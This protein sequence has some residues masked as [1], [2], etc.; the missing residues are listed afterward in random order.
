M[1][2]DRTHECMDRDDLEQLQI[3]RL[4]ATLHRVHQNVAFY[5]QSLDARRIDIGKIRGLADLAELPF[6]TRDDLAKSYPYDM[7][8][9]PLR[10]IVRIHS[11][12]GT[13]GKPNVVGYSH[14]DIQTWAGLI[15]R[16]LCGSGISDHDLVQIAFNY[17]LSTA[18][19]GF[20]YGAEKLGAS[21][22]PSSNENIGRQIMVMRDYKTTAL[23]G[24]PGYALHIAGALAEMNIHP[25]ELHLKIGLLGA[26]PWSENLRAEIERGLRIKAYDNY[27]LTELVGPGIAFE[28]EH[29]NGLHINEDHFIVEVIDP[30]SCR[31]LRPG[32]EGELVFTTVTK[33]GFPLVRYRTGDISALVEGKCACG[34][35][36]VRMKRVAGRTD[37]MLIIDG[38]NV[39]P[40]QI[41]EAL[42]QIDAIEP[43]YQIILDRRNGLDTIEIQVEPSP[44]FPYFD[45]LSRMEQLQNRIK[46]HLD[47]ILGIRTKVTLVEPKTIR[48]SE[49]KK[50]KRVV[51]R[52][53]H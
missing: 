25:E 19:L 10:D 23:I 16:V 53:N 26:E 51:D 6:T 44:R 43:H 11:S 42:L 1:I 31:N 33:Q 49:G 28:C 3:E 35:T 29:R 34:R 41:E 7:F 13:T 50:L 22:I 17:N 45:Q 48:R 5:K 12:S 18:G 24:T 4:Q 39:F 8:A 21:V 2:F 15:A 9:L 47:D 20:H 27:G 32:E 37:D 38:M 14:T 46:Q 52:R 30:V 40:S 36:L